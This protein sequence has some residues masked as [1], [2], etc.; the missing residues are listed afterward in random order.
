MSWWTLWLVFGIIES[1]AKGAGLAATEI[2]TT[3]TT[4]F[5]TLDIQHVHPVRLGLSVQVVSYIV[6]KNS[7]LTL[8]SIRERPSIIGR[9]LSEFPSCDRRGS[10]RE[11]AAFELSWIAMARFS[12]VIAR[13]WHAKHW[14]TEAMKFIQDQIPLI[15]LLRRLH[16]RYHTLLFVSAPRFHRHPNLSEI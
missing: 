15:T 11:S 1:L 7:L 12:W 5:T 14:A 9:L 2:T 13:S 3:T 16:L 4:L 8:C 6:L 10:Q